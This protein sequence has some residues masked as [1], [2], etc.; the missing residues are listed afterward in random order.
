MQLH[1]AAL[2]ARNLSLARRA[3]LDPHAYPLARRHAQD[4]DQ[5]GGTLITTALRRAGHRVVPLE[6]ASSVLKASPD[7][8]VYYYRSLACWARPNSQPRRAGGGMHPACA[9]VEGAAR[10]QR[11][12]TTSLE[13]DSD[14]HWISLGN[15]GPVEVGLFRLER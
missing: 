7:R 14:A 10:W 11:V 5:M 4:L 13:P 15:G 6:G 9:A 12:A 3:T 8:R 2:H 1:G